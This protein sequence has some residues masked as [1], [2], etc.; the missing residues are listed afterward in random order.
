M[1]M[2]Q[3]AILIAL[4]IFSATAF[5][6]TAP[7]G[8]LSGTIT[9]AQNQPVA[10]AT[11]TLLKSD[12][13]VVSGDLT[14]ENGNFA[15]ENT[16]FGKFII[17]INILGFKERYIKDI[18]ITPESPSR[19]IGKITISPDAQ[20]LSEVQIVGERAMMQ[21]QVDKKVFN[22]E[23]NITATGGSATDVLQN[24]PSLTVDP[25]GNVS[26]RGKSNVT[27]L[28]DGKPAT[29]LGGDDASALQSLPASSIANIEVITNPSSKYDAQGMTGIVNIITKKDKKTG[30]NGMV[31]AG[32]GTGDKYNGSLNLNLKND[33]WNVFFNSSYRQN[34][35]RNESTTEANFYDGTPSYYSFEKSLRKFTGWF[36]TLGAEY[37]FNENN[38]LTLTQNLN[39]MEWGGAGNSILKNYQNGVL[40]QIQRRINDNLGSPLS[41]STALNYK[42][43]FKPKQ[44]ITADFTYARNWST[45]EEEYITNYY[46]GAEK[47]LNGPVIQKAPGTGGNSSVN[48]QIDFTTPLLTETDRFE[49]GWK[50]QFFNFESSNDA[51]KRIPGVGEIADTLLQNSY[52]YNQDIHAGYVNYGDQR[53]KWSYQAGLRLEYAAYKGTTMS[54]NGQEYTNEFLNLFPSAFVSY[55]LSKLEN[56]YLNYS[57]RTDRPRF[58]QM[59]PYVNIS[60]LQDT[61][62]GN[63]DLVPEFIHNI[64]LSYSRQFEKGH[65]IIASGYYQYTQN[66][67]ERYRR[68]SEGG[69]FTQPRNLAAGITYGLELIGKAQILPVWDATLSMNFFQTELQGGNISP[70][71]NNT[72]FSWFGKI[73]TNLRLPKNFSLQ[74]NGNYQAPEIEAQGTEKAVYFLDAAIRKSFWKNN[75]S[76][77]LNV[78][79]IFNTRKYSRRYDLL[80]YYQDTYRSRETRVANLTFTYRFG[81]SDVGSRRRPGSA[82]PEN[83]VKNRISTDDDSGE[84][85][86]F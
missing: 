66:L 53:G 72:G 82:K 62:S 27:I 14:K 68:F 2:L 38:I 21:M 57:R 81:R 4:S 79:D 70:E 23:K 76:L 36:N 24:V 50:S 69:S 41:S 11:V 18:N 64:E 31:S 6:Q 5:A 75:A 60:D 71:L 10:Y 32:A 13:S 43:K 7:S 83:R 86:G 15:I 58:Y 29:L 85:G 59:M 17:R 22:V 3:T 63:P 61:T 73:N 47:L 40:N 51:T 54:L 52:N 33:K 49:A 84:Q 56:V 55:Q 74:I 1:K 30:F 77:V 20:M 16:G 42:H 28:I 25:D 34:R 44:E 39:K 48:A 35:S 80:N 9:D 65:N 26:L 19:N 46:D 78:S 45:R 67:I 37:S 8:R 12:S